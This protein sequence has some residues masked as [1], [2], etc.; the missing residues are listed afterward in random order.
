MFGSE[1]CGQGVSGAYYCKEYCAQEKE[2]PM[3][4]NLGSSKTY[5][6]RENVKVE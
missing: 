6:M 1:N 4:V 3:I 2:C 5:F